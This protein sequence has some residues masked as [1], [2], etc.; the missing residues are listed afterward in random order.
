MSEMKKKIAVF[1]SVCI[2]LISGSVMACTG[3]G[4]EAKDGSIIY[5]RTLEFG[6]DFQS[7]LIV[8]PREYQFI[9]QTPDNT[10][11]LSWKTKYAFTGTNASKTLAT[12]DGVNEKGLAVGLFYFPGYA[13][14]Q[15]VSPDQY[16]KSI[17]AWQ[18]G[19]W[20]LS[21]CADTTDVKT[22]LNK[23]KVTD[24]IIPAWGFAPPVHFFIRDAKG[25]TIVVEYFKGKLHIYDDPINVLTNSPTFKWHMTNLQNYLHLSPT[26]VSS[27]N[28][29]SIQLAP[30]GQGSGLVGLPGDFTPPSRFIRAAMLVYS[31]REKDTAE[32]A[33]NQAFHILNQFDIPDGAVRDEVNGKIV[34]EYTLWTSVADLTHKRYCIHTE[35]D[36]QIRCLDLMNQDLEAKNVIVFPLSQKQSILEFQPADASIYTT[37]Q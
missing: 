7:D 35:A 29:G 22:M 14:Y 31:S 16:K 24:A 15:T 32:Q 4:L 28:M 21:N 9:G 13:Q 23:I 20:I 1:L 37:R 17:A 25:K 18:L 36:R 34:Y 19:T 8:V 2:S 27:I 11:G 10:P 3:I 33:I 26:N 6:Q 30:L 5:G 12:V